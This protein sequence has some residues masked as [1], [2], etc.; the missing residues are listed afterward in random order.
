VLVGV[1]DRHTVLERDVRT[2]DIE[3]VRFSDCGDLNVVVGVVV[4]SQELGSRMLLVIR[5]RQSDDRRI[6]VDDRGV[7]R[8]ELAT[9]HTL[10]AEQCFGEGAV[11]LTDEDLV[12]AA[13][14]AREDER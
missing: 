8:R 10:A 2:E 14:S 9:E 11:D 3:D 1:L 7:S 13:S 5:I 6:V 12:V 4:G